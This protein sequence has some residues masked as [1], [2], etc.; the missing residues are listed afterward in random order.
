M[1]DIDSEVL[2]VLHLY[3]LTTGASGVRG[4]EL[5]SPPEVQDLLLRLCCIED[6]VV[7]SVLLD[8]PTAMESSANFNVM[9]A[10]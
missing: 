5:L 7:F 1:A 3:C 10:S 8:L 2:D 4:G 6:Q 9:L